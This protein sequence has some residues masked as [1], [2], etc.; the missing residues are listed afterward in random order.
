[1]KKKSQHGRNVNSRMNSGKSYTL[2]E[3]IYIKKNVYSTF[4]WIDFYSLGLRNY[5]YE[6]S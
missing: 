3:N 6:Q 4:S 2:Y 5:H 1:M